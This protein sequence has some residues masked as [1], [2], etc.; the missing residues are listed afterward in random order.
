MKNFKEKDI[1]KCIVFDPRTLEKIIKKETDENV[2]IHS[3]SGGIF[4]ETQYSN[5]HGYRYFANV[6]SKYFDVKIKSMHCFGEE[7]FKVWIEIA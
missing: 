4:F 6:L 1:K 2:W 3:F 7:D 5:D